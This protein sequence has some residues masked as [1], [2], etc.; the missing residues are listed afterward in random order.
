MTERGAE[1]ETTS[2]R[3]PQFPSP[4]VGEGARVE[5]KPNEGG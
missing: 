4:L 3:Q 1:N 2:A 5:A